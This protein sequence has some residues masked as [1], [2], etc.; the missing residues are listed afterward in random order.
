MSRN[1]PGIKRPSHWTPL[2]AG[3]PDAPKPS[4][5][6]AEFGAPGPYAL[7]VLIATAAS[8]SYTGGPWGCVTLGWVAL[9]Q[10]VGI[11]VKQAKTIVRR[12]AELGEAD[13]AETQTGFSARLTGW[14]KWHG[15]EAKDRTAAERQARKRARD[16]V[17]ASRD[18]TQR[19]R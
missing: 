6:V 15:R 8:Q 13:L 11:D 7:I 19:E 17:T 10:K 18:V 16:A 5:L 14:E 9:A 1:P 12:I 3:F 4:A 2:P